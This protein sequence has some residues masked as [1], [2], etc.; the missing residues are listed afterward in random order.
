MPGAFHIA[1]AHLAELRDNGTIS[2]ADFAQG[3]AKLLA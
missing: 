2:E 3:K 1:Q